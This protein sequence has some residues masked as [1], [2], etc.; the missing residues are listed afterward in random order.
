MSPLAT[1]LS[2]MSAFSVGRYE[3]GDRLRELEHDD[4]EEQRPVRPQVSARAVSSAWVGSLLAMR[5]ADVSTMMP[6]AMRLCE[7][8]RVGPVVG[9]NCGIADAKATS[10]TKMK[11][12]A[13]GTRSASR[14]GASSCSKMPT[15][16]SRSGA[17]RRAGSRA[18]RREDAEDAGEAVL[19]PVEDELDLQ[20]ERERGVDAPQGLRGTARGRGTARRR[21]R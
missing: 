21:R 11:T 13:G 17:A 15:M 14:S 8:G 16:T 9:P 20:L 19:E 7:V 10:R 2:M 6:W 12:C 1:P 18:E 5:G 3:R 4:A